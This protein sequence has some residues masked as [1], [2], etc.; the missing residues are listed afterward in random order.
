MNLIKYVLVNIVETLLRMFPFPCK[1]GM[2]KIG[3][4]DRN[5]PVFLTCNF[6]L[7]VERVK[8]VLRGMDCYLLVASSRGI[9]VWC[10][11]AGG[12][13]TH[14]GVISVLKTSGIEELVDHRTVILPQ[15]AATGVETRIV[16]KKTGW[17]VIWGPVY[18]KKIPGF[19]ENN[20]KKTPEM[21]QVEFSLIQRIE[22]AVSWAFPVSIIITFIVFPFWQE[23]IVPLLLLTWGLSFLTLV[24]F[25]LYHHLL[26]SEGS[27]NG[28]SFFNFERGGIQLILWS[29]LML[30]IVLYT[31]LTGNFTWGSML[32]WGVMLC[33]IILLLTIDIK[34]HTSSY[35]GS[36]LEGELLKVTL[37][38]SRCKVAGFC[39]Q[40]C[41]RNCFELNKDQHA[42]TMPG[43]DRCIKC[44]ACIVQC[45][46]DALS[47]EGLKGEIIPPETIRK[48][49][50]NL[51][52][53]RLKSDK[54]LGT[55]EL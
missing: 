46:F 11:A 18:A 2:I 3:N 23:A 7:T 24:G 33:I 4:P 21:R 53:K 17:K 32:R 9:N 25:P 14:H 30:G 22:G 1:R 5:S 29:V 36:L 35:K 20:F 38:K 54:S 43:A 37:D 40:V 42:A 6:H 13:F 12:H 31:S 47:F 48:F 50:L 15:L 10:A 45:P 34:G 39:E 8:R 28:V 19:V 44:G 52:G 55:S 27:R 51:M 41:P 16:R 26:H 49:K